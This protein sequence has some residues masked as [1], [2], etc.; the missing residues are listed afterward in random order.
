[1]ARFATV[2][3]AACYPP[4]RALRPTRCASAYGGR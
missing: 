1:V 4:G 3:L 2:G